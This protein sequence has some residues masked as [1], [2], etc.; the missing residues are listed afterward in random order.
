[1][2]SL[3]QAVADSARVLQQS[4]ARFALVGGLAVGART[5]PRFTQDFDFAVSVKDD[6]EAEGL[7]RALHR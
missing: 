3:E 1:M 6:A 7:I 2:N 5:E 4:G